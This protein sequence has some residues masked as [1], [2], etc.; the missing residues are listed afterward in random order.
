MHKNEEPPRIHALP[1][2]LRRAIMHM[3]ELNT[4]D[5]ENVVNGLDQYYIP[6]CYPVEAGG[7]AGPITAEEAREALAWA[8]EIATAVRPR[9][10]R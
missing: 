2:L 1:E 5:M 8:E 4:P 10:N 3:P 9:L 7:T 6:T